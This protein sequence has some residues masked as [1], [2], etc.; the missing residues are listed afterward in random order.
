MLPSRTSLSWVSAAITAF[1]ITYTTPANTLA[2][3]TCNDEANMLD[4]FI[5]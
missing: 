5:G 1:F 3:E 2:R 4:D